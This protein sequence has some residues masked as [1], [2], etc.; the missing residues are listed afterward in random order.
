MTALKAKSNAF[1][2]RFALAS[3]LQLINLE[4]KTYTSAQSLASEI[5]NKINSNALIA[6][7]GTSVTVSVEGNAFLISSNSFGSS[8]T[9]NIVS[10]DPATAATLGLSTGNGTPGSNIEGRIGGVQA[11]G[12]ANMLVGTGLASG[13]SIEVMGGETGD[14]GKILFSR[15]IAEELNRTIERISGSDG[16]LSSRTDGLN[17]R[18]GDL[19][20]QREVLDRRMGSL[21]Q[22]LRRQ[23][24][25]LDATLG[26]LQETSNFL[27]NQLSSLPGTRS[28]NGGGR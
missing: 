23:F 25:G 5:Q 14:R 11:N 10:S 3:F 27:S 20:R 15:G 26:S 24:S 28:A 19:D 2:N 1:L 17:S 21:E 8:S 22:R 4:Q 16:L 7:Q 9:V 13:I 18:V 12:S 6:Q